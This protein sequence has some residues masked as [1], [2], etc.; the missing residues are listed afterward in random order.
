MSSTN[1][2]SVKA[3]ARARTQYLIV[4]D[5]LLVWDTLCTLR[6]ESRA[7]WTAKWT[8]MKVLYLLNRYGSMFWCLASGLTI[9]VPFSKGV[10][11]FSLSR[12]G[13]SEELMTS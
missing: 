5:T 11:L 4:F 2:D 9:L 8:L 10:K 1:L 7:I 3:I 12:V 6:L 13:S